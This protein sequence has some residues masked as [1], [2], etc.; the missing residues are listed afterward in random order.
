MISFLSNFE[1]I[2]FLDEKQYR[3][4]MLTCGKIFET[5]KYEVIHQEYGVPPVQNGS[6]HGIGKARYQTAFC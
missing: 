2:G 6:A 1:G 4:Q 5:K 3:S